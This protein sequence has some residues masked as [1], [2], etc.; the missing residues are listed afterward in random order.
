[1]QSRAG[2]INT[3]SFQNILS[4][5]EGGRGLKDKIGIQR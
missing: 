5:K 3:S 1:V 2:R 4:G